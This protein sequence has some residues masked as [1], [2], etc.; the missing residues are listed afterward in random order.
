MPPVVPFCR[1]AGDGPTVLCLHANASHSG[2]WRPLMDRLADRFHVVAIDSYGA[3]RT[4]EWPCSRD[5][6]LSD[7]VV[8]LDSVLARASSPAY[9]VGHSYGAAVALK[10]A[11]LQPGRFSGLALYE[12]TFFS[13]VDRVTPRE[14]D[15]IR[16]T[17][18]AAGRMLD[19]GD[20][21]GAA[22]CFVDFWTGVGS[23]DALAPDR[24]PA[25]AQSVRNI[26]RWAHA[27]F[28]EPAT[29][30]ELSALSMPILYM[31]GSASPRSSLSVAE[32]LLRTLPNAR[33]IVFPGLGHMAPVTHAT[34]VNVEIERF[35]QEVVQETSRAE[36][37]E[38]RQLR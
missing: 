12:P 19:E 14:V 24:K 36:Q 28:S 16:A 17:A 32:L 5:T 22:R 9:L 7:E 30:G 37:V 4:A 31:T 1:E 21:D 20:Q 15:G 8:L 13:V 29:L 10:A 26:R 38:I 18:T 3:G 23:W 11:L 27:L 33:G 34:Q 25:M 2:Q 6:E 35:L